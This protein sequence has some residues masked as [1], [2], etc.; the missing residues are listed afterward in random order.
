M[1]II[2]NPKIRDQIDAC[3]VYTSNLVPELQQSKL[4]IENIDAFCQIFISENRS[5]ITEEI[6]NRLDGELSIG[7]F[8]VLSTGLMS[9]FLQ[10]EGL[11]LIDPTWINSNQVPDPNLVL[12]MMLG[13]I[14]NYSLGIIG[15]IELGLE[16]QARTCLRSMLELTWLTLITVNDK[17][18][19][20]VYTKDEDDSESRKSYHKHFSS[21]KL[22]E[23]L[24]T[25]EIN[26]GF[27]KNAQEQLFQMRREFYSMYSGNIHHS[28]ADLIHG[29]MSFSFDK[30]DHLQPNLFGKADKAS[31]PTLHHMNDAIFVFLG[32]LVQTLEKQ[33][34][35][36]SPYPENLQKIISLRECFNFLVMNREKANIL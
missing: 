20:R 12:G 5:Q 15:L 23:S 10:F 7:Y 14:T 28:Y 21:K 34:G 26:L 22:W 2:S 25:I 33:H 29:A 9:F 6:R 35:L 18:K 32:L 24:S 16:V 19:M 8:A 3:L 11:R 27:P 4:G 31:Y 1:Q 17:E 30:A 13:N 36:S